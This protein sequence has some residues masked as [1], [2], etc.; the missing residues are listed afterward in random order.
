[1][2]HTFLT[3][4]SIGILDS[5]PEGVYV[6]DKEF[7]IVYVNA[8]ASSITGI[9]R[10]E[11]V[12]KIC[13]T[14]CRSERCELGC[15]ITEVLRSGKNILGLEST[16]QS[17]DGTIL[18]ITLNASLLKNE[19]GQPIGGIISFREKS[20]TDFGEY[21]NHHPH[22]YGIVGKSE[23]MK[24]IYK[25]IEQIAVSDATVLITGETGT[26]KELVADAIHKTSRRREQPFVKVNCAALPDA[27]LGS[28]LF[29][30]MKG[31]FT[32]AV[33][34][35][36]GRFEIANGGT[37]FLDEIGEMS[38]HMQTQLLR[39]LQEGTFER[40][41]E[42]VTRK[43]D[44]RILAATNKD[45]KT[46]IAKNRFREDLYY[47]LN[48][49]PLAVPPLRERKEDIPL[50]AEHFLRKYERRYAKQ[51][52]QVSPQALDILVHYNWTGN[53]RE[54]ENAI[55]YAF[56]R[57]KRTDTLCE[58]CLPPQLLNNQQCDGYKSI[59]EIEADH[60]TETILSLLRQ[61][62]WNKTKVARLLGVNRS[63]IHRKLKNI[64][65]P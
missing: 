3:E 42:S 44:V 23:P 65:Q 16:L 4:H 6:V 55:E 49:I 52:K 35:R 9:S 37:L 57:S 14:F 34:D 28:E 43:T 47:R 39:V 58:C 18:P 30:H 32:D 56:V 62:N 53:I 5:L 61:H 51:I 17:S 10:N 46:E 26:G 41:G 54:L 24:K 50:L 27:L 21:L 7:H 60:K 19:R 38:L 1:M 29:G 63:T 12:G 48:V 13:R 31:A 33:K 25:T 64:D 45:L 40:V 8:A 20:G 59:K 15:P 36:I 11:V 22:F 2:D